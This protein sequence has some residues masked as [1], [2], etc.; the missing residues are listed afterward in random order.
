[1]RQKTKA[2]HWKAVTKT[3][4]KLYKRR[5]LK[6]YIDINKGGPKIFLMRMNLIIIPKKT[7]EED[8]GA[9]AKSKKMEKLLVELLEQERK[10]ANAE[11]KIKEIKRKL[12]QL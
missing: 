9:K 1:M 4:G 2:N 10:N 12:L 5:P 7:T 11:R 3:Y 8:P 6:E